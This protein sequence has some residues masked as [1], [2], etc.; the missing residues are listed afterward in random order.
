[1]TPE[2]WR[3]ISRL[4]RAVLDQETGGRTAF[5]VEACGADVELRQTIEALLDDQETARGFLSAPAL[6]EIV[7]ALTNPNP[8]STGHMAGRR[9][10]QY[11]IRKEIGCGGMGTVYLADRVDDSSQ[12]QVAIKVV[13]PGFAEQPKRFMCRPTPSSAIGASPSSGCFASSKVRRRS[14][15]CRSS[16]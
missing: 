13:R 10:G 8:A 3:E 2:R 1:M 14:D 16:P 15:F 12:K 9:L 5:L 4:Y 7:H 6:E 11:Q